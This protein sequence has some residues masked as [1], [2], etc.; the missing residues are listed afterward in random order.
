MHPIVRYILDVLFFS[1]GNYIL[2][3][4]GALIVFI[5]TIVISII[6]QRIKKKFS[7]PGE[8]INGWKN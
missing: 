6:F 7:M 8:N 1:F 5:F 2:M 3:W 4:V